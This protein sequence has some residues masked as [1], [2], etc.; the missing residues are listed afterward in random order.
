MSRKIYLQIGEDW[1]ELK[2]MNAGDLEVLVKNEIP[3]LAKKLEASDVDFLVQALNEK[4]YNLKYIAFLLLQSSF[5][6][7]PFVYEYWSELEKKLED[8]NSQQHSLGVML[9]AENVKWDRD[10][11][12]NHAIWQVLKVLQR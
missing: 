1:V 8:S 2:K 3:A 10:D 11:K 6:E 7:F 12:L 9:I 5:R 4:E